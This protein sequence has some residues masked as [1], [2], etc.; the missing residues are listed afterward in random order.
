[1]QN[2]L[3][4]VLIRLLAMERDEIMDVVKS[5]EDDIE[6]VL[7]RISE[8]FEINTLAS[9]PMRLDKTA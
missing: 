3:L 4:L 6:N 7:A 5:G 2:R 9:V 8:A 1:M